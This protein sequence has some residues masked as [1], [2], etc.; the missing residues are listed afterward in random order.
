[1]IQISKE[2]AMSIKENLRGVNVTITGQG[3]KS[4][5]KRYYTEDTQFVSRYLSRLRSNK[6][7][8]HYE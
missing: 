3:H 8:E 7:T 5:G 6:K 2:E 4:K 1:M